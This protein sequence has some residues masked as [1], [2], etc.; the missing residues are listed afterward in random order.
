[1]DASSQYEAEVICPSVEELEG[2]LLHVSPQGVL[3]RHKKKRSSR[4]ITRW[5]SSENL[6]AVVGGQGKQG[7]V[8]VNSSR[9]SVF[10]VDLKN[11]GKLVDG[12]KFIEATTADGAPALF[13]TKFSVVQIEESGEGGKRGRKPAPKA[14]K[15]AA[16]P[17]QAKGNVIPL[18][19]RGRVP[20][21]NLRLP[22]KPKGNRVSLKW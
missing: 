13:S 7:T 9:V 21:S 6:L 22:D 20:A 11:H 12:G 15:A 3:I 2:T 5:I 17:V 8:V 1:M 4:M 10:S 16:A 19:K 18:A 14:A